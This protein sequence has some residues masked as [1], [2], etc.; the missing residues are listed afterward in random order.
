MLQGVG[1]YVLQGVDLH[2][3]VVPA[4]LWQE[5]LQSALNQ[6]ISDTISAGFIRL[7]LQRINLFQK[8]ILY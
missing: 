2:V 3:Y 8:Y 6:V 7:V 5:H 1:L 4:E